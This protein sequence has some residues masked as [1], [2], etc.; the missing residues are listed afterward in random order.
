MG[1]VGPIDYTLLLASSSI[2]RRA[3]IGL[4][5]GGD[6]RLRRAVDVPHAHRSGERC[7]RQYRSGSEQKNG[8]VGDLGFRHRHLA[9]IVD[10]DRTLEMAFGSALYER[11]YNISARAPHITGYGKSHPKSTKIS[12]PAGVSSDGDRKT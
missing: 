2:N 10:S 12:L 6:V 1:L 9:H 7:I 4:G 11:A 3:R 8:Q 5:G